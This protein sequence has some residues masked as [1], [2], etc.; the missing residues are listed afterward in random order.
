MYSIIYPT[1]NHLPKKSKNEPNPTKDYQ[2]PQ[3]PQLQEPQ[4]PLQ[5]EP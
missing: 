1:T 2:Q 3:P 5:F 4:L